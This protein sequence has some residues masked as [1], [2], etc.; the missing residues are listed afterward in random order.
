MRDLTMNEIGFISGGNGDSGAVSTEQ[1]KPDGNGS[2]AL[3]DQSSLAQDITNAY[4]G[5]IEATVYVME[6]VADAVN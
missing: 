6:R 2:S 1:C 4:E 3:G 5:A